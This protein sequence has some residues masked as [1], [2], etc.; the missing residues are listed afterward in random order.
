MDDERYFRELDVA[1]RAA[2][3]RLGPVLQA[4]APVYSATDQNLRS[5]GAVFEGEASDPTATAQATLVARLADELRCFW[6]L[7]SRGHLVS[8]WVPK[9]GRR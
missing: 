9:R 5:L 8:T 3:D 2:G 1:E 4:F 6:L 7:R